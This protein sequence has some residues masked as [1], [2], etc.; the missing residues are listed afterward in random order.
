MYHQCYKNTF[1][2]YISIAYNEGRRKAAGVVSINFTHYAMCVSVLS[3]EHAG[4]RREKTV[5]KK[6]DE[7]VCV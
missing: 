3:G 4:A 7:R 2:V 6:K 5:N 1:S